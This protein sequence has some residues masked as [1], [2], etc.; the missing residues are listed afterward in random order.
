[1]QSHDRLP[2]TGRHVVAMESIYYAF[3][4]ALCILF[5]LW[6]AGIYI[7]SK[8]A[9]QIGPGNRVS[10]SWLVQKYFTAFVFPPPDPP[11]EL[12]SEGRLLAGTSVPRK[13]ALCCAAAEETAFD[14]S[15]TCLG[16]F[17]RPL[18]S[19]V[20]VTLITMPIWSSLQQST[21]YP[22][23]SDSS[24][25]T[26]GLYA[27]QACDDLLAGLADR[28]LT[29]FETF[30]TAT[31]VFSGSPLFLFVSIGSSGSGS[32]LSEVQGWRMFWVFFSLACLVWWGF[33]VATPAILLMQ[34]NQMAQPL[35]TGSEFDVCRLQSQPVAFEEF[36]DAVTATRKLNLIFVV[37]PAVVFAGMLALQG[38]AHND[39]P[40]P[41]A[42]AGLEDE[43]E[44]NVVSLD[45]PANASSGGGLAHDEANVGLDQS[46]ASGDMST[47]DDIYET[48]DSTP[49]NTSQGQARV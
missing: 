27:T 23:V 12:D 17:F 10:D 33:L 2:V 13:R 28:L 30:L 5:V 34:S 47:A 16:L 11:A 8:A 19:V 26:Q 44:A 36:M 42:H 45:Q 4:V 48:S 6:S 31:V 22:V 43:P 1:M 20:A 37:V 24:N 25:A 29:P 49:L 41:A 39:K 38:G 32:N 9:F 40:D 35:L 46:N 3:I 7:F 18:A 15:H 21:L 14:A